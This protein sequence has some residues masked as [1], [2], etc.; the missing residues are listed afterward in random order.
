MPGQHVYES[1]K[2]RILRVVAVLQLFIRVG[3]SFPADV[4]N[5]VHRKAIGSF[6][7]FSFFKKLLDVLQGLAPVSQFPPVSLAAEANGL[8]ASLS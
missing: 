2:D 6:L 3:T 4:T 7:W 1:P 5:G 8:C